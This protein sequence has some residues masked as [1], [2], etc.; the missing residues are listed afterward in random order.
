MTIETKTTEKDLEEIKQFFWPKRRRLRGTWPAIKMTI[1]LWKNLWCE[2][3]LYF[4]CL[5]Y[6]IWHYRAF[7]KM[8]V[9]FHGD[10]GFL[11][12]MEYF[13]IVD[14]QIDRIKSL[15]AI[16]NQPTEISMPSN[17]GSYYGPPMIPKSLE[18]IYKEHMQLN[19]EIEVKE[20]HD[21]FPNDSKYEG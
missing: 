7:R 8:K 20:S 6:Y 10:W 18:Q 3:K 17:G 5:I 19:E 14:P 13:V 12:Q 15:M 9:K 11:S 21:F 4:E 2:A 1:G 16:F